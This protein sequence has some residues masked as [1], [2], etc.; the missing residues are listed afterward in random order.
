MFVD[1]ILTTSPIAKIF[2]V[3]AAI[4]FLNRLRIPLGAALII[5]GLL[6]DLWT[7]KDGA[8]II[9]DFSLGL[10]HPEFWLLLLNIVLIL[11]FGYFM[12]TGPNS[13]IIASLAQR[14]G[15]RYG[16]LVSLIFMPA[17]IGMVPMPGGA[18]FSAPLVEE[19]VKGRKLDPA[20]KASVNYWFRHILEYWWP[21]Y[22]V[23][24]VSL[25][26]FDLKTH[27]YFL[28]M[29]PFTLVSLVSG[30][31][32]LLAKRVHILLDQG[33]GEGGKEIGGAFRVLLPIAIIV[34][35]T[36]TL[37][38]LFDRLIPG[39][40][41]TMD[42]LLGMLSGL[43]I[44]LVLIGAWTRRG[45]EYRLFGQLL[46][47]KTGGV[48]VTL[49]GVMIFQSFL[50][51]SGLLPAAGEQLV[52]SSAPPELI[53][54]FLPFLAGLVTGIAIG[55]AGPAFPLVVGLADNLTDMSQGSALVLAFTTGY[56]GMM[57]SPVHLCYVLTRRYFH[58]PL[59]ATYKYLLPCL[60]PVI[61]YGIAVYSLMHFMG[62]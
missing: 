9:A 37:P 29:A 23:V 1:T 60:A 4:L 12:T 35:C 47:A 25:S 45:G 14:L 5:G 33:E 49:G 36:L 48:V 8:T 30:W 7:G 52:R 56:V 58:V 62:W 32:F 44:S 13:K 17:A 21:L 18:L 46:T 59:P 31:F 50:D 61:G 42:N 19:A 57:L 15:G 20:W 41:A 28:L 55:F 11:E 43:T 3:F 27:E 34:V 16:R 2:L 6:L 22:P 10:A 54:A 24:I 40:S 51:A 38:G 26:I 53:I 39:G